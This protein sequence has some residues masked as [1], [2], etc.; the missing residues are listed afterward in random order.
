MPLSFSS[1]IVKEFAEI[2]KQRKLTE[3]YDTEIDEL[4]R[5]GFGDDQIDAHLFQKYGFPSDYRKRRDQARG[6]LA[7]PA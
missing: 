5:R 2:S 7:E 1:G 6:L 3:R 4:R